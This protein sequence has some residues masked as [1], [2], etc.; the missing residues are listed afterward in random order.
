MTYMY[1]TRMITRRQSSGSL[2]PILCLVHLQCNPYFHVY[3]V[4]STSLEE[5]LTK[6][7]NQSYL[8]KTMP[9]CAASRQVC[10][11]MVR[12]PQQIL[13]LPVNLRPLVSLIPQ[14][15]I[16]KSNFPS[17][18]K[19]RKTKTLKIVPSSKQ[20]TKTCHTEEWQSVQTKQTERIHRKTPN[21]P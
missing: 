20:K 16:L 18:E 9:P 13:T 7:R 3:M 11:R 12:E 19:K 2:V 4:H 5:I 8:S 15:P 14:T 10:K 1:A 21:Q 17:K 6:F